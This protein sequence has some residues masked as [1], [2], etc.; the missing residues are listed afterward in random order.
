MAKSNGFF[1]LRRGSTKSLT[2]SVLEGKQITKDRVT[3]VHN[4]K[5]DK[6]QYQRAIMATVM[7]AYSKMKAI[8]DHAFQGKSKGAANQREFYRLNINKLRANLIAGADGEYEGVPVGLLAPKHLTVL[9]NEYVISNGSLPSQKLFS[10]VKPS[11]V[12]DSVFL[13]ID[14]E[15]I[16]L[17]LTGKTEVYVA[18][19]AEELG[20]L[21]NSQITFCL[22][23]ISNGTPMY[24]LSLGSKKGYYFPY[25][26]TYGRIVFNDTDAKFVVTGTETRERVLNAVHQLFTLGV[27]TQKT[28]PSIAAAI[29]N[30]NVFSAVGNNWGI[31]PEDMLYN[32]GFDQSVTCAMG[33]ITSRDETNERDTSYME[34]WN[35]SGLQDPFILPAWQGDGAS[36]GD[37][38]LYLE[39]GSV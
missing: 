6:Q 14:E 20:I 1:S 21:P 8:E 35:D 19:L 32:I 39:G 9:P 18:D 4:P 13:K 33:I 38:N 25:E 34:V 36:L 15:K 23:S 31:D 17:F 37:S 2:F 3:N 11:N 29:A 10:I 22:I 28:T 24:T 30:N 26:F 7:G 16:G 27:D 5:T 12:G